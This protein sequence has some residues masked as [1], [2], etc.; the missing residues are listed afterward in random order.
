MEHGIRQVAYFKFHYI[1]QNMENP[2]EDKRAKFLKIYADIPEG[3]RKDIVVVV[4]KQPYT[5]N[6]SFIEIEG[7]TSLGEKILKALKNMG[8]I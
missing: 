8:I 6:T 4:D 5:W 2:K 1:L 7:N 3:L